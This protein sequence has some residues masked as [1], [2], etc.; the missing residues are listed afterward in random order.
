MIEL[1]QT[2]VKEIRDAHKNGESPAAL[3][4]LLVERITVGNR[5]KFM[6]YFKEAAFSLSLGKAKAV[7][8]WKGV[9]GDLSDEKIN[10]ILDS[11]IGG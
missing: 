9:G 7:L 10:A 11:F 8:T 6:L 1:D 2:I 3:L 4:K 5:L